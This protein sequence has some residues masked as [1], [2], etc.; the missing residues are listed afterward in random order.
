MAGQVVKPNTFPTKRL[1]ASITPSSMS[2]RISDILGWDGVALTPSDLGDQ[3]Y[4]CFRDASGT[5]LE[6]F[7]YDPSTIA[8][9]SITILRRGLKYTGDRTTEVTANKLTWV[10]G[11]TLIELGTTMPQFFQWLKEYID[12][13]SIAGAVPATTV[14]QGIVKTSVAPVSAANPIAVS[15]NDTRIPQNAHATD[16]GAANAYVISLSATL[17]AYAVGQRFTFKAANAN[18]GAST[19][20]VNAIG[21]K[22]IKKDASGALAAGDII[23]GQIYEVEYDGTNFQLMSRTATRT[24]DQQTFTTAGANTWV[25]PN[26]GLYVRVQ[27]WAGGGSGASRQGSVVDATGGGGG[28]YKEKWF[29]MADIAGN[30]TV[31]IGAGGVAV[32]GNTNGNDGGNTTFG[33]LLTAYGGR[34]GTQGGTING[35]DGGGGDNLGGVG[36]GKGA[37]AGVATT[38]QFWGGGAS[39]GAN[40][41]SSAGTGGNSWWGGAGGGTTSNGSAN[42]GGTSVEGGNG[43]AGS[44]SG[45]ATAGVQPGGGGGGH[46]VNDAGNS[47]KGG[48]GKAIITVV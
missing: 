37:A 35:A 17:V 2:F 29:R 16:T 3:S 25:Q 9:T 18:T 46:A 41:T 38:D 47:G 40:S 14:V 6:L 45:N 43:G 30:Q 5:V 24:L 4:G 11:T 26:Q 19:L 8:S 13:A 42:A 10:K 15:D 22:S 33:A 27:L 7:E 36:A 31:T 39:A 28:A 32:A 21:A 12:A 48:D 23:V 1:S 44:I 20:N 34:G